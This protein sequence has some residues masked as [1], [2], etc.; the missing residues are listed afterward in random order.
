M[1]LPA[2]GSK[3]WTAMNAAMSHWQKRNTA[4]WQSMRNPWMLQSLLCQ[5]LVIDNDISCKGGR[6]GH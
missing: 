5:C 6:S 1:G 4:E 3:C 2:F